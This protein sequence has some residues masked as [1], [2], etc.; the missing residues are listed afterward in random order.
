M[1]PLLIIRQK[2]T[3]GSSIALA[4]ISSLVVL[5]LILSMALLF[6]VSKSPVAFQKGAAITFVDD[7]AIR[8]TTS[9]SYVDIRTLV[10]SIPYRDKPGDVYAVD[11]E[12]KYK[13][14]ILQGN[15]NCSQMA[16]GL[17]Y[18][19]SR[20]GQTYQIVHLL[21]PDGFL[22][23]QGHTVLNMPI[24]LDGKGQNGIVDLLEGGIPTVNNVPL[25]VADLRGGNLV[26]PAMH[27][28][29][30][31]RDDS[32]PYYGDFLNGA[33]IGVIQAKDVECYF[34]FIETIYVPLGSRKLETNL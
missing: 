22:A 34:G 18:E 16:F 23:G 31:G 7:S 12:D 13:Q 6:F 2:V 32:S 15:G 20:R 1:R 24:S 28:L 14:T 4:K 33:I 10:G 25:T 19:L 9:K 11:P 26:N 3:L 5:G 21:P 27:S 29:N 30:A 8:E 17:G